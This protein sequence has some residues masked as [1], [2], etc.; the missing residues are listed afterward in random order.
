MMHGFYVVPVSHEF[1]FVLGVLQYVQARLSSPAIVEA[2]LKSASFN[3]N[4]NNDST[5][6]CFMNLH[7]GHNN[8]F[9]RE[10]KIQLQSIVEQATTAPIG[11]TTLE[12]HTSQRSLV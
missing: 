2:S 12:Q 7:C 11:S 4:D 1:Q 8:S 10:E 6:G 5:V 3:V 9:L